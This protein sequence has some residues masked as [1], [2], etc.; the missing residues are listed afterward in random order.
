[1]SLTL[2]AVAVLIL[3]L[4]VRLERGPIVLDGA[5]IRLAALAEASLREDGG[6]ELTV[7]VGE[8]RIGLGGE[9]VP[10][11]GLYLA[12]VRVGRPDGRTLVAAPL[13]RIGFRPLDLLA[14]RLRLTAIT[15]HGAALELRRDARGRLV[16]DLALSESDETD[17]PGALSGM[18][19]RLLRH[20]PELLETL[21]TVSFEGT[22]LALQDWR[23]GREIAFRGVSMRLTREVGGLH[24]TL[25][26]S[27]PG[28]GGL[29]G[30]DVRYGADRILR[31]EAAARGFSPADL[32]GLDPALE[33]LASVRMPLEAVGRFSLLPDG[34]LSDARTEIAL[35]PGML[36]LG[37]DNAP[38]PV[39]AFQLAAGLD[40]A[41]R[42][43][44]LERLSITALGAA[45]SASGL[46]EPL[47]D[48]ATGAV[49]G[50]VATLSLGPV[51]LPLGDPMA[52]PQPPGA[53]FDGGTL[54]A[55]FGDAPWQI[56]IAEAHLARGEAGFGLSGTLAQTEAGWTSRLH[57]RIRSLSVS[58][59]VALW[60]EGVAP[61][62]K[63]W[64]AEHMLGG[65][66]T[67]AEAFVR[68]PLDDPQAT[69][70]FAFRDASAAVL[71]PM[72]P[73]VEGRGW[74]TVDA[75][76]FALT[77]E[78]GRVPVPGP[79]GGT[80]S[81]DGSSFRLDDLDDDNVPA[82]ITVLGRGPLPAILTLIGSEP[83][84]LMDR[85]AITPAD[86]GG[87]AETTVSLRVPLLRDLL[88]EQVQVSAEASLADV[89]LGG[90]I[91][92]TSLSA[93][94]LRLRADTERL[95]VEG[96]GRLGEKAVDLVWDETFAP[97]AETPRTVV[98]LTAALD[99]SSLGDLALPPAMDLRLGAPLP[100]QA[101]LVRDGPG[102][103]ADETGIEATV[104]LRGLSASIP[105][106]GWRKATGAAGRLRLS[107]VAGRGVRLD[108]LEF[109]AAGLS[110][111]G[112]GAFR[113]DGA[114]S[115]LDLTR[116]RVADATD[117]AVSLVRDGDT[118][119]ADI[120]GSRLDAVPLIEVLGGED[121]APE[122]TGTPLR[123]TLAVDR[124][125][126][127]A[128]R[129]LDGVEARILRDAAGSLSAS[130]R[131]TLDGGAPARLTFERPSGRD[132][133][134]HLTSA[135]AGTLLR[136]AGLFPRALGG[137]LDIAATLRRD[138]AAEGVA[139]IDDVIVS[140]DA[141]LDELLA[142]AD[143]DAALE[144]LQRE[145]IRFQTV[146]APFRLGDG[147]LTL[148]DAVAHGPV[149]GLT[150]SGDYHL[151]TDALNM[152]GVFTPLYGVNSLIGNVP[153]IGTLLTGGEGQ[154]LIAFTFDLAGTASAP[155]AT[156][157]PLSMLLPGALRE[158]IRP[159]A[160]PG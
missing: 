30:L 15:V 88:L 131:G 55:R 38:V 96:A 4:A 139:R 44:T 153:V 121:G 108:R 46:V 111:R 142:G 106:L 3:A 50:A 53:R 151:D 16:G 24:A 25:R 98:S 147:R 92:P 75:E 91:L 86:V 90:A 67:E 109:D 107:G 129:G 45:L 31:G 47:R 13:I 110:L 19:D 94:A 125:A 52:V 133:Q 64:V 62:A 113:S 17:E 120:S 149:I 150:I 48:T 18:L 61:G 1:M 58:E 37:P 70:S 102:L 134:V 159:R 20:P 126:L 27:V 104:D 77:L 83:L 103:G 11:P 34:S 29:I 137:N 122:T 7:T 8:A 152:E 42:R 118:L 60:P 72:P 146:R 123:L 12:D 105:A 101:T 141:G 100:V 97:D 85:V 23:P 81:L 136:S 89:T 68:G 56:E 135:D 84:A 5:A 157:H 54:V 148:L 79:T 33:A 35:G 117:V 116:L 144:T 124:L 114:M 2:G 138:G 28:S 95:R 14:G 59:M 115:R 143:L 63:R 155:R 32:A 112:R 145:G 9:A 41:T 160:A 51:I 73:I 128:G 65:L 140:D 87:T 40:P 74:G 10:A 99:G 21:R 93:P 66:V 82:E 57:G 130:F 156:V 6:P 39:E 22:D 36:D 132:G 26:V 71:P 154:G 49:A 80:L 76:G 158:L 69:L 78:H 119:T 127:R 43:I